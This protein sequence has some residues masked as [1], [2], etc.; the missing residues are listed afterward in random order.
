MSQFMFRRADPAD[1]P[2]HFALFSGEPFPPPKPP[3]TPF[4]MSVKLGIVEPPC[5]VVLTTVEKIERGAFRQDRPSQSL[6]I[7]ENTVR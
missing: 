5:G 7:P 2:L 1:Q 3:L 6:Q 4:G